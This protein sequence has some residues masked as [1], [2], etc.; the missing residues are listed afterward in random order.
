[1][2]SNKLVRGVSAWLFG[3][4]TTVFLIAM[5]GR[6]VVVDVGALEEA[7]APLANS[8]A[9]VELLT[10]WLEDELV[11]A[12]VPPVTSEMIVEEVMTGSSVAGALQQFTGEFVAAAAN[13]S[14]RA[15]V[16][17][18]SGLLEPAVPEIDA[19]LDAAGVPASESRIAN[20]VADL[21]PLV[22][23]GSGTE[24]YVGPQS[25]AAGRLGTAAVLAL[26]LMGLAGWISVVS[27]EDR[28]AQARSL[29]NRVALGALSFAVLLKAGSWLLDPRGGRAPLSESASLLAESKWVFVMTLGIAAAAGAAVV[30]SVRYLR[31]KEGS[32]PPDESP[33]QQRERQPI[34]SG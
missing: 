9:V 1:V 7:S 12:E 11:T 27:S 15:S 32:P 14:P 21:D 5:W 6:A 19:A 29:L 8:S 25:P 34:R 28:L 24:P 22:V 16:V 23:R 20:A 33:T 10:G 17:D 18:M 26:G 31:R 30:W 2:T 4:A 3:L 13:P